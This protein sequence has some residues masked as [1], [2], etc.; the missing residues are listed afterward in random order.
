MP[1]SLLED[2]NKLLIVTYITQIYF[3]PSMILMILYSCVSISMK[4]VIKRIY[5]VS[6]ST[7]W[8][9]YWRGIEIFVCNIVEKTHVLTNR[10]VV[11]NVH[12]EEM[13]LYSILSNKV[14]QVFFAHLEILWQEIGDRLHSVLERCAPI[15][16]SQS[17]RFQ[18]W[19]NQ[20][21]CWKWGT[22]QRWVLSEW[23][24]SDGQV[25]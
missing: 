18:L 17:S 1:C 7:P 16:C 25:I 22:E 9:P 10:M 5:F 6:L 23:L 13:L 2:E 19:R 24:A 4:H 3:K 20:P 12:L 11:H 15:C 8:A 14:Y 21:Y